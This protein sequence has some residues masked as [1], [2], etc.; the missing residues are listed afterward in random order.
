MSNSLVRKESIV[1]PFHECPI[2]E[3]GL[4]SELAI[5]IGN[6]IFDELVGA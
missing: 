3:S 6:K 4:L 5:I 2:D 1:V